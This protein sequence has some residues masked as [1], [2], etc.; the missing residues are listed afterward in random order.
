[1]SDD[2]SHLPTDAAAGPLSVP[3]ATQFGA[4]LHVRLGEL[5][6]SKSRIKG[7]LE[8]ARRYSLRKPDPKQPKQ[9][10]MAAENS[11]GLMIANPVHHLALISRMIQFLDLD[12]KVHQQVYDIDRAKE[13]LERVSAMVFGKLAQLDPVIR[14][15][16]VEEFKA[17]NREFQI[18][19]E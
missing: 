16:L 18:G 10:E 5:E 14:D 15:E 8:R 4:P 19:A 12:L 2:E 11:D 6:D 3:A 13:Y 9:V 7:E 17:L 1:M